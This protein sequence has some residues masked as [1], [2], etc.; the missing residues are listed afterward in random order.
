MFAD[1]NI[2]LRPGHHCCQPLHDYLGLTGSVRMSMGF[3][4]TQ[5]EIEKFFVVLES[6]L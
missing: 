2:C 6:L 3:D 1:E 4:T 5:E